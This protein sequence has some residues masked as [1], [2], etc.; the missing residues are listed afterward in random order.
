MKIPLIILGVLGPPNSA[1]P[2]TPTNLL[3]TIRI[4]V[5]IAQIVNTTT[6]NP[7]LPAGTSKDTP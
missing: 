5:T 2:N 3:I 6:L 7:R 1:L 4:R